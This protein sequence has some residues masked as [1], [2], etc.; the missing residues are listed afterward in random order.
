MKRKIVKK[1]SALA[2]AGILLV[3]GCGS[4]MTAAPHASNKADFSN[5]Y[6]ASDTWV[7]YWY[8][9]GTDLETENGAASLDLEELQKVSLPPNVKVVIQTGG[10]NQWH[11]DGIPSRGTGRFLY[12]SDGLRSLGNVPDMNMGSGDGLADFLRFGKENFTADHSVF[13]FWDHGGG[14]AGGICLDERHQTIMS[15]NEV[16]DAFDSVYG[17]NPDNPPFEIIGFDACLMASVDT[18]ASIHGFSRYMVASQESEPGC[19]WNYTGWVGALA[20]NPAIGGAALGKVICDTYLAGCKEYDVD[21]IATL[22]VSD[23][24]KA[25]AL[26]S[27]YGAYGVEALQAAADNPRQLFSNL[28]RAADASENYGGNTREQG[29]YDMVD[30]GELAKNTETTLPATAG[31]L[32]SALEDCVLYRVNGAYRPGGQGL[33][34]YHP[35]DGDANVWRE[36]AKLDVSPAPIKYLYYYLIFGQ[37]PDAAREYLTG[38]PAYTPEAAPSGTGAA[39]S[40]SAPTAAPVTGSHPIY[41]VRQ[42]EDTP[43]DIDN[44]GAAFV[45][46]PS[47]AT[48]MLSSVHCQLMYMDERQDIMLFL[49]SDSNIIA[50]W[51]TGRFTDNFFGTWPMLEG[52]PVYVEITYEG[53]GFNLYSIPIKLNGVP[54]NLQV[55]YDFKTEKYRILG[56]RKDD[57]EGIASL[58]ASRELIRLKPGDTITTLHYGMTMTGPDT[59]PTEV[60]V[61]TFTIGASPEVRDEKVGD[62]TYGYFFEFID[63]LNNSAL[64]NMV[65]YTI[66]NGQITTSVDN[67]GT[68]ATGALG[69]FAETGYGADPGLLQTNAGSDIASQL[70]GDNSGNN[71]GN[72]GGGIADQLTNGGGYSDSYSG[73]TDGGIAGSLG[74]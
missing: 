35:Y 42:L 54:C 69:G 62:G 70:T 4:D 60:E 28:S 15:L 12:D 40:A 50:D 19:G 34:C 37:M 5:A 25:P 17:A 43:V 59:E 72:S 31:P 22:S 10:A 38:A 18:L 47:S 52:H 61:D 14:S 21:E 3:T 33:S 36:Y 13:V 55:V 64:S 2:A 57:A 39:I 58:V 68:G 48:E 44:D 9:C 30:I 20:D 41:N 6:S 8:L 66:Q 63:P 23:V 51:N 73:G 67:S 56:A 27:A 46:L 11:T 7:V 49:G 1:L 16:R 26:L 45:L 53:D 29:Y 71:G 74:R 65:T 24:S 32:I